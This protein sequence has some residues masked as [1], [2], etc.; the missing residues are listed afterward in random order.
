M[1]NIEF[2]G[3]VMKKINKFLVISGILAG[4]SLMP[5]A[6]VALRADETDKISEG[7]YIGN[8]YV[9]GM[10]K[11]EAKEAVQTY[12]E[13]VDS[14][15]ITLLAGEKSVE[16]TGAELGIEFSDMSVIE[17]AMDVG[18]GGNLIKRYKDKKDLANGDKIIDLR[19][20]VN[21]DTV[22]ELLEEKGSKLNQEATDNG[23]T[24][25]NGKFVF[26]KG[27]QGIEVNVEES[28]AAIESF[29]RDKWN[30]DEAEIELV[31]EIVEP[32]GSEEE[33]S[34]IT[35]LLGGYSTNYKDSNANR[36]ANIAIAAE[37]IDGTILYPGEEFSVADTIGP[38][39]ASNGYKLAGAYE[40]GQ[41]V[42]AYGGGV[43]QVSTTLYNTVI[44]AELEVTERSNHSMIVGYVQPSMDAAIAGD[45]KDLC[46]VNNQDTP[47]YIEGYTVGK[48]ITFNIY[49]HETR[50]KNRV[51]T[52]ES[53]IVSRQN[54]GIQFVATGHPVGY[55]GV[56]QSAHVGY[57]ARL[58]KVVTVN[59]VEE[60]RE[61]FNK[62]TYRA[63]P[64]IVNVGTATEDANVAATIGAAIATGDEATIYAAVAPY[65]ANANAILNPVQ[66]PAAPPATEPPAAP[67]VTEPPAAP[68]AT[69]SPAAAPP[70]TPAEGT[71]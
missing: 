68:P 46:F 39:N 12:V 2:K 8:V 67:P 9:G 36:C 62:S 50:P 35:D 27:E 65:A 58:W 38:L 14:V 49:G 60:S 54:P 44:L 48:D 64:K 17:E 5:V 19:L 56:A 20:S 59:G 26:L 23:L 37:M 71:Q 61:I 13:D 32:R 42:E 66:P 43:C 24:R 52:Y 45:Y 70:T 41:T 3:D 47:I 4:L 1:C 21:H 22:S 6:S 18:R 10:T 33:L 34:Q 30:E 16:V 55:I 57:V 63:S 7:V 31:A 53:E 25:E 28:I 69:E 11:E 40:N 29:V 51:V 15:K